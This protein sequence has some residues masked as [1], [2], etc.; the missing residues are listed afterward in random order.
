[1]TGIRPLPQVEQL[2]PYQPGKPIEELQRELG[3]TRVSKLASNEN[4]LG[5]SPQVISALEKASQEIARYPDGSAY[6]LKRRL[7]A[8]HSVEPEMIVVGNGSNEVLELVVRAFAGP[9]DEVIYDQH[10]FAVYP[11]STRAAGATGVVVP[12]SE[13][14]AHDLDAMAAAVT[15]RTRL[16]FLA[17][18]NN[19]TGTYFG[20]SEFERFMQAVP[21]RVLVVLD[22]A[23][24][25]FV[26]HSDKLDGSQLLDRYA[27][28]VVT[29]TFSKVYGLASLR[30]G[31]LLARPE[32]ADYL[33]RVR[34]PF[35]TSHFAQ[36]A[37]MAALDDQAF[38]QRSVAYNREALAELK[39]TADRFALETLPAYGNFLTVHFGPEANAVNNA[40]L[41]QGVIVRPLAGYGMAQWLRI[42]TGTPEEQAHLAE[43]LE[44]ILHV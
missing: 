15:N 12:S 24:F 34:E 14:F 17:N 9:G 27:N 2:I 31:Y 33:N 43:A 4:P 30:I 10:A 39:A 22:E 20:R 42:S 35:N 44:T 38:V 13:G 32:I 3:L 19:P 1:M 23:Y 16:I 25:E 7:A 5:A 41:K 18:P 40:L 26:S 37:A 28:L 29:R 6:A 11:L 36:L 21:E 8:F